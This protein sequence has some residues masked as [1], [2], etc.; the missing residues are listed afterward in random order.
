MDYKVA[1]GVKPLDRQQLIKVYEEAR[2]V[3]VKKVDE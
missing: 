1:F 2:Q 3:K